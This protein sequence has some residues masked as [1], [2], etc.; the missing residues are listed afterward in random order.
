MSLLIVGCGYVGKHVV[1]KYLDLARNDAEPPHIYATTRSSDRVRELERIGVQAIVCDWLDS[2]EVAKLPRTKHV[3]VSV[4]HREVPPHGIESHVIGLQAIHT[5]LETESRL[6]YLSTTGVYGNVAN[7]QVDENTPVSPTRA[8]PNVAVRAE[9]WLASND[10]LKQC[11]TLRLAGI[12]G[13]GR[14][15]LAT[16]LKAGEALSVPQHGH[17]NLIHVQDIA[18]VICSLFTHE[19]QDN[20]YV[21]SDGHPVQR[22]IFYRELAKQCGVSNPVF[23]TPDD[24]DPRQRRATDKRVNPAKIINELEIRLDYPNYRLGLEQALS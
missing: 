20:L 9:E 5:L 1:R 7:E 10:A 3:L 17:L 23:A 8:G 11:V 21:L 16:K 15:P 19:L 12:Y 14:I 22:E 24:A 18:S 13:A 6:I 2:K 4:P